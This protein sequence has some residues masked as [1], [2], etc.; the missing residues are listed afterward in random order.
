MFRGGPAADS[1]GELLAVEALT[2]M[3]ACLMMAATGFNQASCA[4]AW[5]TGRCRARRKRRNCGGTVRNLEIKSI[6][7]IQSAFC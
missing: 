1:P 6:L 3:F 4:T 5:G 2:G 7:A